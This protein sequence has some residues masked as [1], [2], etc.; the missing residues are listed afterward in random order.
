VVNLEGYSVEE[1]MEILG[2]GRTQTVNLYKRE[3]V[4]KYGRKY[5][6]TEEQM[7]RMKNRKQTMKTPRED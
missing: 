3:K 2:I 7:L 6:A 1:G 5:C 4:Q